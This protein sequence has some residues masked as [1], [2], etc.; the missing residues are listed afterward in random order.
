MGKADGKH[1]STKKAPPAVRKG[2][3]KP[4][5]ARQ[6]TKRELEQ[7]IRDGLVMDLRA[8]IAAEN[9]K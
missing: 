4:S 2:H 9:L 8:V 5:T 3:V 1:H 6:L 7:A